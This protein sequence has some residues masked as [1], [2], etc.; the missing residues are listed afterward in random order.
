MKNI[1]VFVS[2][3][4]GDRAQLAGM[5]GM[6]QNLNNPYKHVAYHE[7]EDLR[8]QGENAIKN[9]LRQ[10]IKKCDAVICM[11]GENTHSSRWVKYELEVARSLNKKIIAVR[12]KGTSGGLSQL[13]KSWGESEVKWDAQAINDELSK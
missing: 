11:I 6:L 8:P 3:K 5:K 10:I 12:I 1:K 13:L 9:H 7:R 2:Y 4:G